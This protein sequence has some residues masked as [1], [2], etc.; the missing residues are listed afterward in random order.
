LPKTKKPPSVSH[1][2]WLRAKYGL[3]EKPLSAKADN[4]DNANADK[5][6]LDGTRAAGE[7]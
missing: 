7:Y 2:Q 3:P 5:N 1:G 6:M 4:D